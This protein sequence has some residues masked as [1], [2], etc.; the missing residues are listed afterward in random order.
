MS[1]VQIENCVYVHVYIIYIALDVLT[2]V[3][4]QSSFSLHFSMLVA[5]LLVQ[6]LALGAEVDMA[7]VA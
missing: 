4:K 6:A 2:H 3:R 1:I 5:F 7:R